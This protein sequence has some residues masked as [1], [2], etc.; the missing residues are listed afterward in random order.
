VLETARGGILREGL[1]Y[2]A[3]D[4]GVVTNIS[5]D[6]LGLRGVET[7]E[8]LA[9]VKQVVIEAVHRRG[10]AVLNADDRLVAAMAAATEAAVIYFSL[11]PKNAV[12]NAHAAEDGRSVILVDGTIV[13]QTGTEKLDLIEVEQV[14]FT[15]RGKVR[16]QVANA[17]AAA[18]AAW[19][20]G[21]NPAIIARALTTF[22]SDASVV[23]GRFNVMQIDGVEVVLDYAHNHAAMAALADA[24]ASLD[25][26]RT[27]MVMGL[28]RDRRD[29]DLVATGLA[30]LPIAD[31]YVLHDTEDLRGR[32]ALEVPQLLKSALSLD[33]RCEIVAGS[34][35]AIQRGW[36]CAK[37]GDRLLII[38]YEVDSALET[39]QSLARASDDEGS[40]NARIVPAAIT[41]S[42]NRNV[43]V[44]PH[45]E[46]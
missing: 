25:K 33:G 45:R 11:D 37:P 21:V 41:D 36:Q 24:V 2:D 30:S 32:R 18:A 3:V 9:R 40:C 35:G 4:V 31:H 17:L 26:R 1:G 19:G 29:E 28:P 16:F 43:D 7:V 27:V 12:I 42:S 46:R 22:R 38:A 44:H 13:L 34:N 6:H 39:L 14:P 8:D 15:G 20:A 23:P 5:A 10:T